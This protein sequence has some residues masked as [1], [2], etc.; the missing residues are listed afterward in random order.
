MPISIAI[1]RSVTLASPLSFAQQ[2]HESMSFFITSKG[3]CNGADL[4]GLA[5]ADAHCAQF[6]KNIGAG[7]KTWRAYLST[8]GSD[9]VNARDR[10]GAG[11]WSNARG[12]QVAADVAELHG[13]NELSKEASLDEQGG[14]VNGRGNSPNRHDIMTGSNA[15]GTAHDSN[16]DNWSGAGFTGAAR[17]GHHDRTGGGSAPSSWNSAHDSR[18]CTQFNLK[19]SGG[20]G[21]YYCFAAD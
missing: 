6:A 17:V 12:V 4:G 7:A 14:V 21:L 11:P 8:T 3:L 20:D 2:A 10:I 5:G 19:S 9:G 13:A 16:C 1:A 18:G 15:D